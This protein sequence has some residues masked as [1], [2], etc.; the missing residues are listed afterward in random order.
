LATRSPFRPHPSARGSRRRSGGSSR[1]RRRRGPCSR[2]CS[3][4]A[5]RRRV[6]QLRRLDREHEPER[7]ALARDAG[8]R[9]GQ[10]AAHR[11]GEAAADREAQ[12]RASVAPAD[13]RVDLA[14]R[15]EQQVHPVGRDADAGVADFDRGSPRRAASRR[16]RHRVDGEHDL[17]AVGE[18][19]RVREQVEDDLAEPAL[20]AEDRLGQAVAQR[21]GQLDAL[22]RR[23]RGHD[24][25]GALDRG[26]ERE[27]LGLEVDLAR[28]DLREVEDVVDD[29]E[30]RVAARPDRLGEVALLRV[31]L[32]LEQEP[33]HA[34]D[35]V[36][37]RPDLVAH[38]RQ[39]RALRLVR[40]LGR[41]LRFLGL[42][43]QPRV[44]DR[45]RG[46][47]GEAD[48]EAEVGVGERAPPPSAR[49]P[50]P[51]SPGRERSAARP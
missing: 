23:G 46:L 17:A 36:H 24:V 34:D 41:G 51:R 12:A 26:P 16:G 25:E 37:R 27:R 33:A 49:P 48:Q 44:L 15:L 14:E 20:V 50:R 39:E 8:A 19:D 32:G 1:C 31:E 11:L 43:E 47:S 5:W 7:A 29:R 2:E 38:R 21:V 22:P 10:G 18:L 42:P 30:Q 6:G 45:D 4:R 35:R 40:A 28:L 13:R 3:A 9:R